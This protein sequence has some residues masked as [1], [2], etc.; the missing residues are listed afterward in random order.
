MKF[1][2][3][4]N[5]SPL[6]S[7]L[8]ADA[9]HDAVHVRDLDLKQSRDEII[10][11]T[12]RRETQVVISADADFGQLLAT[13]NASRRSSSCAASKA[14]APHRSRHRSPTT[15]TPSPTTYTPAP[16]SSSTTASASAPSP[17]KPTNSGHYPAVADTVVALYRCRYRTPRR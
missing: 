16:S 1:L 8:L 11:D 7:E 5:L 13:T 17:S 12:A 9:G 14:D 4:E 6:L 15:S 2:L 3:D 10:L